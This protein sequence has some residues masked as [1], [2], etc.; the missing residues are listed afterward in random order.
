VRLVRYG[1]GVDARPGLRLGRKDFFDGG[2]IH[3]PLHK[4]RLPRP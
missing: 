1:I 3:C 4:D 2:S